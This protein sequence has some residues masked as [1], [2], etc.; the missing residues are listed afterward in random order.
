MKKKE[1]IFYESK[2]FPSPGPEILELKTGNKGSIMEEG[3]AQGL[4]VQ[5]TERKIQN[6]WKNDFPSQQYKIAI[7]LPIV[8]VIHCFQNTQ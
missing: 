8:R 6:F 3:V 5:L 4:E 2:S 7:I 1:V